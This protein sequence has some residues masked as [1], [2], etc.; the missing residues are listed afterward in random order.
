MARH[1][2]PIELID[3]SDEDENINPIP[4][5]EPILIEENDGKKYYCMLN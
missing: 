2:L 3:S 1:I 5:L 4:P